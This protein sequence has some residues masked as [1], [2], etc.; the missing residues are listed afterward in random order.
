M[1]QRLVQQR[2]LDSQ[3]PP[4]KKLAEILRCNRQRL[5]PRPGKRCSSAQLPELQPP[6]SPRIDKT[7]LPPTGQSQPGMRVRSHRPRRRGHQQP[8]SHPQVYDPLSHWLLRAAHLAQL[9]HNMLSHPANPK[10]HPALKPPGL[11]LWRSL[12]RFRMRSKPNLDNAVSPQSLIDSARNR[13][14]FGQFRHSCILAGLHIDTN[15]VHH[16]NPVYHQKW[17]IGQVPRL[18]F[19]QT[20]SPVSCVPSIPTEA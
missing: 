1:Q 8:P 2:S 14:H 13:L 15:S 9:T 18:E 10:N 11:L 12:E 20:Q 7:H 4:A 5:P 17:R 16:P 3:L 19:N 6:K